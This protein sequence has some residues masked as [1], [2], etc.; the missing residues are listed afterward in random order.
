[1]AD[2]SCQMSKK[3]YDK[4]SASLTPKVK[5]IATCVVKQLAAF[6]QS[7]TRAHFSTR[8]VKK[9]AFSGYRYLTGTACHSAATNMQDSRRDL[10]R[11]TLTAANFFD[12]PN[13][14]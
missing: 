3:T 14:E 7:A 8:R 5:S 11:C 1:M 4:F 12:N 2:R 9:L 13:R 10:F 6:V